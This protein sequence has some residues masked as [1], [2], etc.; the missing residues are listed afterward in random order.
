M[1]ITMRDAMSATSHHCI[2]VSRYAFPEPKGRDARSW[3][4]AT[5]RRDFYLG[6]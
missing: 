1:P 2:P 5:L 3:G 6:A 4:K